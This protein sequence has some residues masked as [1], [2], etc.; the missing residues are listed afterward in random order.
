VIDVVSVSR[1][2]SGGGNA[3]RGYL[4]VA[5]IVLTVL[6]STH[7]WNPFPK[8][9]SWLNTSRPI[10]AGVSQWQQ[11]IGGSPQS[12]TIA[13]DAVIVEYR[14]SIEAY[15][16]GAGVKLWGSDADWAVVA[17]EGT[18]AVVVTGR[19]LKKGYQ[20]VDPRSGTIRRADTEATAVWG[21]RNAIVDLHCGKGGA[22]ELTAWD[23][24]GSVRWRVS[25]GGIGFV[26]NAANPDLPDTNPMTAAGI[27]DDVAGPRQMPALLGLPDDGKVR[28]IDTATGKLVQT[29]EPHADQRVAVAGGRLLTITGTAAD[30][31]CY[32][33][34]RATDPPGGDT[35]WQRDGLNL[36]TA[37][38]GSSCKQDRDPAGGEDVVLGV[39][40]V[41]RPELLAAHDGRVLW[42]GGK[43]EEAL[44]VDDGFAVIRNGGKSTL[45]CI[46]LAGGGT[47]W[48]RPAGSGAS[49]A[50]SPYAVVTVTTKPARVVALVPSSGRVLVDVRTDAKVF[51]VGP[52]GLIAVDGRDMA[53][54]PF[55]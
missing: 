3:A 53:Y 49:A 51:A 38:N 31:T 16:L 33:G 27:D 19:L 34:V 37:S 29:A 17:G 22:C 21:Y 25:T 26:L 44:A 23:P 47:A 46:S 41:G 15:G 5:V 36:R 20:V 28:V 35:V 45:R 40:P 8:I 10:A 6:I 12:V 2:A 13:N 39:D 9:W 48:S 32:Y 24:R 43:G 1:M 4:M 18:D 11:T 55:R 52:A 7:T 50:L 42:Q 30:G 54:V 14:T